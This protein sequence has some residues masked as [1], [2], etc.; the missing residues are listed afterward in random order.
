MLSK[1][2]Q[3]IMANLKLFCA[4]S[5]V[6]IRIGFT[7][8]SKV[9][10]LFKVWSTLFCIS[11][12]VLVVKEAMVVELFVVVVGVEDGINDKLQTFP[13]SLLL[14]I[15]A[16]SILIDIQSTPVWILHHLFFINN[17]PIE[18]LAYDMSDLTEMS[19]GRELQFGNRLMT[20]I[21]CLCGGIAYGY[22]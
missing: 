12:S 19:L 20:S 8:F 14:T 6:H 13:C 5:I 7:K 17:D 2:Q 10:F 3:F 1:L 11:Y 18:R 9:S 21:V 4:K 15:L 16:D 22:S